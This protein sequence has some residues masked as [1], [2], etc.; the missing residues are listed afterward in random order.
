MALIV[1]E[2]IVVT[3]YTENQVVRM[4]WPSCRIV[5]ARVRVVR[6]RGIVHH[7]G[8][9]FVTCYGNPVGRVVCLNASTF[10][11]LSSF[12]TFRP[13]GIAVWNG[14]LVVTQ[15]NRGRVVL[16]DR[17]GRTKQRLDGFHEPRDVCVHGD[18]AYVADTASDSVVGVDLVNGKRSVVNTLARPN[19]VATDGVTTITSLWNSGT[20]VL[21]S[22]N[23]TVLRTYAGHTPCMASVTNGRYIVC[24]DSANCMYVFDTP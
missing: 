6:P 20:I 15:V 10:E 1:G 22:R 7:E 14:L 3:S 13:R 11:I 23:G 12:R 19:G 17:N 2:S 24:D 8:C 18:V 16:F 5:Q 4:E 9:L 21:Q